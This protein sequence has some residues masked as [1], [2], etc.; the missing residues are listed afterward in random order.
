MRYRLYVLL[1]P[2]EDGSGTVLSREVAPKSWST[3]S[4][5]ERRKVRRRLASIPSLE[6]SN[7]PN[8]FDS[9]EERM[10]VQRVLDSVLGSWVMSRTPSHGVL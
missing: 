1:A 10:N 6:V 8:I 3:D 9:I 7:R 4:I 5:R 2:M